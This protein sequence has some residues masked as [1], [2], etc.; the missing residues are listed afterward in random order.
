MDSAPLCLA[1]V[2]RQILD[3]TKTINVIYRQSLRTPC[4][5]PRPVAR[6][7]YLPSIVNSIM[8]FPIFKPMTLTRASPSIHKYTKSR[9]P[10]TEAPLVLLEEQRG[11]SIPIDTNLLVVDSHIPVGVRIVISLHQVLDLY[12]GNARHRAMRNTL[13]NDALSSMSFKNTL[14]PQENQ[15]DSFSRRPITTTLILA[16]DLIHQ[17]FWGFRIHLEMQSMHLAR[18]DGKETDLL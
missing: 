12:I 8:R 17:T 15:R 5:S 2:S 14:P 9:H 11:P 13:R 16:S 4:P 3:G 6:T 1:F 7:L 10:G 18:G